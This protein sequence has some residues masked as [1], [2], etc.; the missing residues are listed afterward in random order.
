VNVIKFQKTT[1]LF[2]L[3]QRSKVR[4]LREI[5][6]SECLFLADVVLTALYGCRSGNP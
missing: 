3:I 1:T 5:N 6:F 2:S 4:I